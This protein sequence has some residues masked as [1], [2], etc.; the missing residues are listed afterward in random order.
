MRRKRK[1][2]SVDIEAKVTAA[3][4]GR[5]RKDERAG[6]GRVHV[7][8]SDDGRDDIRM[9]APKSVREMWNDREI[10]VRCDGG[11]LGNC[12]GPT[13]KYEDRDRCENRS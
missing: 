9:Y 1:K 4:Q 13:V 7:E 8:K 5:E 11:R 6:D 10:Q 12:S 2:L 3:D